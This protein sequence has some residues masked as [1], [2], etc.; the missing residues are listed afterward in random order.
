MRTGPTNVTNPWQRPVRR[1][2]LLS[3]DRRPPVRRHARSTGPAAARSAVLTGAR[4]FGHLP[5]VS[6]V[7]RSR[8]KLA[9]RSPVAMSSAAPPAEH[10]AARRFRARRRW[11]GRGRACSGNYGGDRMSFRA[12]ARPTFAERRSPTT[13]PP[14]IVADAKN[15][16]QAPAPAE[17][18]KRPPAGLD[19]L[20]FKG[21][22]R[23]RWAAAWRG[24][25]SP[26]ATRRPPHGRPIANPSRSASRLVAP[27]LISGARNRAPSRLPD[28][29]I[30]NR[31]GAIHGEPRHRKT[32]LH[33]ADD[34]ER[35]RWSS[36]AGRRSARAKRG[37]GGGSSVQQPRWGDATGR[38]RL[39]V[40]IASS[41]ICFAAAGHD[42]RAATLRPTYVYVDGE[43]VV[44]PIS[45]LYRY[46]ELGLVTAADVPAR[47]WPK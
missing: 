21:G 11:R 5:C 17:R 30:E 41:P 2:R 22:G 24:G 4:F 12:A 36:A 31:Q 45:V 40:L 26:R 18:H 42:H 28:G 39:I 33:S 3:A 32:A 1:L 46:A 44:L 15:I 20:G 23:Q 6:R 16:R 35:R 8:P 43:A 25:L 47:V 7:R 27:A 13:G 19:D 29:M 9:S 38:A 14:V 10:L 34:A 37:A